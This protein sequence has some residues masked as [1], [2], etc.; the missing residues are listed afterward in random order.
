MRSFVTACNWHFQDCLILHF[1][2]F[3][4]T[5]E[6]NDLQNLRNVKTISKYLTNVNFQ[7]FLEQR[8]TKSHIFPANNLRFKKHTPK[9]AA[10]KRLVHGYIFIIT[11]TGDRPYVVTSKSA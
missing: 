1:F 10:L 4:G 5:L 7:L 9:M 8:S 3:L 6:V 11:T 2:L